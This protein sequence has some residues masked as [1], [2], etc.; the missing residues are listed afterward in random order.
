[1]LWIAI[2]LPTAKLF[3]ILETKDSRLQIQCLIKKEIMNCGLSLPLCSNHP[4]FQNT[5][6]PIG[7][8]HGISDNAS[9][10]EAGM[11]R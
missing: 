8:F 6:L 4:S 9:A 2:I 5:Y 1:M 3:P 11:E 10:A 7:P